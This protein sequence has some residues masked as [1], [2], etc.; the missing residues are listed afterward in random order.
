MFPKKHSFAY[1]YL[2]VAVPV[3]FE[4]LCGSLIS[5]GDVKKKGW[6]HVQGSDYLDRNSSETTLEGKLSEYLQTQVRRSIAII[7][8]CI[9]TS[10]GVNRTDWHHAYLVT[11]PRILG[12]S[13][14]PVSFWYLYTKDNHL[15]VMVLEVNNTFDERRMYLLRSTP[16]EE[17]EIEETQAETT[18]KFKNTWA[19]DFHVSPFNSRKGFYSLSASD[20]FVNPGSPPKF[21]NTIV[22]KSSKEHA[23]IIARVF[24]DGEPIKP[25]IAGF[26]NVL[27]FM[28]R[29]GLVG[30]FTFPRILK[31][32]SNLFFKRKLHVWLRPEVLPTSLGRMATS[33]EV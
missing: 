5:V 12:Y 11:A 27:R 24:C 10:K 2:Q 25:T 16:A 29:W 31:E 4:G 7:H 26:W 23:K 15:N 14:N 1:S 13:F 3:G 32:A 30:F 8:C 6:L 18:Q 20:A 21:D 28:M 22:M 19:K 33:L 9:L 17:V